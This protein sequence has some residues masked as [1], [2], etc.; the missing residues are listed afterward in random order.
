MKTLRFAVAGKGGTGKTTFSA[1][2]I[3]EFIRRGYTPVLAVDADPNSNLGDLLGLKYTETI[4]DIREELRN[5][6]IIPSNMSKSDFVN[7]RLNEIIIEGKSVDLI[8][9]GRPEGKECYCYVN[10]ILR[11]FLSKLSSNYKI[12]IIDNEAGMEHLSRRT[13]DNIDALFIL[14]DSS[15]SSLRAAERIYK[16]TTTLKLRIEKK[17]SVLNRSNNLPP[18]KVPVA[19]AEFLGMIP[20]DKKLFELSEA[21][22][23]LTKIR[24]DSPAQGQVRKILDKVM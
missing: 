15:A 19:G 8:V 20:Y 2:T 10:E 17:Y 16:M 7:M 22:E 5:P 12:V 24:D 1:L 11:G 21:G 14:A 9:M 18:G 6:D 23:S 4:S 13:T 3:M